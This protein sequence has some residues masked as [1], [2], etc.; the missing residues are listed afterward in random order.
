MTDMTEEEVLEEVDAF[1]EEKSQE[2]LEISDYVFDDLEIPEAD[3]DIP[4]IEL[5][6]FDINLEYD[7]SISA[8]DITV[9]SP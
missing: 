1:F 4:D 2:S 6:A 5:D 3:I 9:S 7:P 8:P